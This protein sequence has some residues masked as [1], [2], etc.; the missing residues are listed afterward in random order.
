MVA[1]LLWEQDVAG[2]NPVIPTK[3]K[4]H[5][6]AVVLFL[7]LTWWLIRSALKAARLLIG[8]ACETLQVIESCHSDQREAPLPLLWCFFFG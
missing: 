6:F 4:H 1:R 7:W 3:E 5:C 8:L 2:S